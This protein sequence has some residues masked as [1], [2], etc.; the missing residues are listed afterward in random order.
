MEDSEGSTALELARQALGIA[1]GNSLDILKHNKDYVELKNAIQEDELNKLD[2]LADDA[3]KAVEFQQ[4]VC[5]AMDKTLGKIAGGV[6]VVKSNPV[7]NPC[8]KKIKPLMKKA[9][10]AGGA[11]DKFRQQKVT[12]KVISAT[13]RMNLW[14]T[15]YLISF[16]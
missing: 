4:N 15:N 11:A 12:F 8:R 9:K 13:H 10:K 16:A 1:K 3:W 2:K 5:D 7:T 6:G 14:K